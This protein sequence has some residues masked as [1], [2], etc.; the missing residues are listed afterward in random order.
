MLKGI[1]MPMTSH[2]R[3]HI[4]KMQ[5]AYQEQ[6]NKSE[7]DERDFRRSDALQQERFLTSLGFVEP[8]D[9]DADHILAEDEPSQDGG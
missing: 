8:A 7:N 5:N 2:E 9:E 3:K 4:L 6:R 1:S